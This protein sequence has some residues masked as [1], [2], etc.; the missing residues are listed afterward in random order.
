[1]RNEAKRRMT[2]EIPLKFQVRDFFYFIF[3]FD[4]FDKLVSRLIIQRSVL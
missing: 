2:E 3:Y 1:M 4:A